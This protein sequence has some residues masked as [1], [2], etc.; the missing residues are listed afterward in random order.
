MRSMHIDISVDIS[1][2]PQGVLGV[3]ADVRAD[4]GEHAFTLGVLTVG[5]GISVTSWRVAGGESRVE[6]PLVRV[7]GASF[8]LD[9]DV[10]VRH[11]VCLGSDIEADL[12]YPFLNPHEVFFGTGLLP[13]PREACTAE[14]RLTGL[15][16]GWSEFSSLAPGGMHAD[17]LSAFFCYCAPCAAP[18]E[19]VWR[20]RAQEVKF[21]VLTQRGV[22]LPVPA[23]ELFGFVD[24][25][26]NW[27]E[28]SLAPYS[29]AAEINFLMLRAP[30]DFQALAGGRT[31]AS[32][33][34]VLNGIACYAPDD[35]RYLR[36]F[37]GFS[38]YEQYLY[39]GLAHELMHFYTS[40]ALEAREKTV[41]YPAPDCPAYAA[42]LL[43]EALNN[44]FYSGYVARHVPSAS[45]S[46]DN[47]LSRARARREKTGARQP[48]LD[49]QELDE[50]LRAN[51][52]SLL[53]L[54]RELILSRLTDRRPYGSAAILFETM[55]SKLRLEPPEALEKAIMDR[56]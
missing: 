3:R 15:P 56:R 55:R 7:A 35:A 16:A 51:G 42:N 26:M 1:R 10:A 47:W 43:G 41:L 4:P 30:A 50:Y 53:D 36:E 27:L 8:S 13:I 28:R 37:F 32:G 33:E 17:K 12:L 39:E 52:A 2:Y 23:G 34:N 44:Y 31:F 54:F 24:G 11:G 14:F 29:R 25:Y 49:L 48:F 19:H 9:Y 46:F 40:P 38:T 45:G 22:R 18:A 6:G 5:N 21:R 20:G